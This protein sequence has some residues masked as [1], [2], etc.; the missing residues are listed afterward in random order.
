MPHELGGAR[1]C[2]GDRRRRP[3]RRAGTAARYISPATRLQGFFVWD[4]ITYL[5]EGV[6]FL[7]TGLQAR[8]VAETLE[9]GQWQTLAFAAAA[10][11]VALVVVRF[12]WSLA[13]R[14]AA[15]LL[16]APAARTRSCAGNWRYIFMV[17]F[18]GIR[19]VV[20]LAAA[21]SILL[22]WRGASAFPER[23]LL[24]L[25]TFAVIRGD[26]GGPGS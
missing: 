18:T 1:A 6:I 8:M 9:L 3:V 21:L 22:S 14:L 10:V 23:G 24:L 19:G 25:V 4:L 20:S 26:P 11:V 12:V 7:L 5:I 2:A 17:G 15:R 16:V 13:G